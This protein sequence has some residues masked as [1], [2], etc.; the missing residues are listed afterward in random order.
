MCGA[1]YGIQKANF[2]A[3]MALPRIQTAPP[4]ARK[5]GREDVIGIPETAKVRGSAIG[6]GR[7]LG[8]GEVSIVAVLFRA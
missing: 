4:P 5:Q 7:S 2:Q 8:I 1:I 6:I 3:V